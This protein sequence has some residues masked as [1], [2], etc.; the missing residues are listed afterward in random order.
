LL[1]YSVVDSTL[2][3]AGDISCCEGNGVDAPCLMAQCPLVAEEP[4]APF[5]GLPVDPFVAEIVR[6]KC[7]CPAPQV[8][9][10]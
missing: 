2:P 1:I 10:M 6:G 9:D 7:V 5:G 8:C 3:F 4:L